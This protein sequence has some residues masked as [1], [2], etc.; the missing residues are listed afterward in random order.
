MQRRLKIPR[1][2]MQ[3]PGCLSLAVFRAISMLNRLNTKHLKCCAVDLTAARKNPRQFSFPKPWL[4]IKMGIELTRVSLRKCICE[5]AGQGN[6]VNTPSQY[7]LPFEIELHV[8]R[9]PL[10]AIVQCKLLLR[11]QV[12]ISCTMAVRTFPRCLRKG[13]GSGLAADPSMWYH[14]R[15][16]PI[17]VVATMTQP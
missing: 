13:R 17:E 7:S 2:A 11:G 14:Q 4:H 9:G 8:N 5:L 16:C 15:L 10:G 3:R 1:R 12:E 6:D